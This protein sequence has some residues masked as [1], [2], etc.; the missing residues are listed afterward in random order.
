MKDFEG[1][2]SVLLEKYLLDIANASCH[3]STRNYAFVFSMDY[4]SVVI[5]VSPSELRTREE[6]MS[7][8]MWVDDLKQFHTTV[9][10]PYTSAKNKA[11]EEF[12]VG[13]NRY[14]AALFRRAE[15]KIVMHEGWNNRYFYNAGVSLGK[16]HKASADGYALGFR[17]KRR[18][19]YEKA[20]YNFDSFRYALTDEIIAIMNETKAKIMSIPQTPQTYSMIHGDYW[21]GNYFASGDDIWVFDFDDCGY[22]YFMFDIVTSISQWLQE[23]KF[24]PQVKRRDLLYKNGMLDS[25]KRGYLE[26]YTLPKEAWNDLELFLRLRYMEQLTIMIPVFD[27]RLRESIGFDMVEVDKK[28]VLAKDDFYDVLD[29]LA[30]NLLK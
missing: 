15:G 21:P 22:G 14:R 4:C 1:I 24:M 10:Q 19:W 3:F 13:G 25:F 11:I 5:R 30:Q 17:Y 27:D 29:K 28:I 7:E 16:L 18:H 20:T 23:P 9:C 12:E 2:R 6:V 26:N 8:F